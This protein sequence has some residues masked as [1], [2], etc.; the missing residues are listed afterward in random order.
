MHPVRCIQNRIRTMNFIII[1]NNYFNFKAMKI[2]SIAGLNFITR[3]NFII[4]IIFDSLYNLVILDI[5]DIR[6]KL[7]KCSYYY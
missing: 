7:V 1:I 5:F 4:R 2:F 3:I 6:I